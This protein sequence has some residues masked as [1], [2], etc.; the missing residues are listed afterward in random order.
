ME[1]N[2]K[3]LLRNDDQL[4][5]ELEL[6]IITHGKFMTS[7]EKSAPEE[8]KVLREVI[9]R[10]MNDRDYY[11]LEIHKLKKEI[12][13]LEYKNKENRRQIAFWEHKEKG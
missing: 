6:G 7:L 1:N 10:L 11:E 4:D 8:V 13:I 2:K 3:G 5:T 12:T 9:K